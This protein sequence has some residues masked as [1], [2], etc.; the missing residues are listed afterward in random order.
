MIRCLFITNKLGNLL[1]ERFHGV[2]QDER[3]Q[4]RAFLV[5]LGGQNLHDVAGE[6]QCV[7]RFKSLFVVYTVVSDLFLYVVGEGEYD[8]L[9]CAE[10]LQAVVA[11]LKDV[12]RRAPTEA[13]VLDKYGRV[14][15]ALDEVVAQ[16]ILEHT[17]PARIHRLA[18]LKP[19]E[20]Y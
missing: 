9:G 18:R 1:L 13:A 20:G 8:E 16:G 19:L 17:D 6:E 11:C 5:K 10:V 4:F 3:G 12:C 14:C 7:A 15:L 2:S